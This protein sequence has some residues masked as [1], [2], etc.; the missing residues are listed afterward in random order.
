[1]ACDTAVKSQGSGARPEQ[2]PKAAIRYDS[3]KAKDHGADDYGMKKYIFA[4]LM[5]GPNRNL[6]SAEAA[7]LQIAH[8]KNIQKM[9]ADGK[10]VLAGPFLDMGEIRGIYIFNVKNMD[11]AEKLTNTDPAIQAGSLSME[12]RPWYGP[13]ALM[14]LDDIHKT[15]AKLGITEETED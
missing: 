6:D 7:T 2:N 15:L 3:I 12:L 4:F 1:M 11:E 5:R 13:A 8:L 14:D 10:L 9:T